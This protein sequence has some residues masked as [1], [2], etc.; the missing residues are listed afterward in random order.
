VAVDPNAIGFISLGN[1]DKT[2]KAL[3]L[4]GV[5]PSEKTVFNGSYKIS[6]PFFYVTKDQPQG[7]AQAFINFVLNPEGQAIVESTKLVPVH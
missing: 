6:R 7:L 3:A 2:V 4:G 5:Q 1:L